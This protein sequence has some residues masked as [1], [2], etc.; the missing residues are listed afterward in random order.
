M[1]CMRGGFVIQRHIELRDQEP[2]LL[3]MVCKDVVTKPVLQDVD[4]EQLTRGWNNR[5]QRARLDVHAC[6]FWEHQ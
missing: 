3:N 1:N 5:A 4:G 2:E 6:V